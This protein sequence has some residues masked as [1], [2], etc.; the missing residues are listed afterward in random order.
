[1]FKYNHVQVIFNR[2]KVVPKFLNKNADIF[3]NNG[4]F[5][6]NNFVTNIVK[7]SHDTFFEA[8]KFPIVLGQYLCLIPL[9]QKKPQWFSFQILISLAMICCQTLMA[10]L[11]LLWLN[12]SGISIFKSG[13]VLF[14]GGAAI[15]MLLMIRLSFMWSKLLKKWTEIEYHFG[16]Q[17][18]LKRVFAIIS[19]L[20]IVFSTVLLN[21]VEHLSNLLFGLLTTYQNSRKILKIYS[22]KMFPQVFE[23]VPYTV[24]RA[25]PIL[26]INFVSTLTYSFGDQLIIMISLALGNY[27]HLFNKE[28]FSIKGKVLSEFEWKILR[29]KY[30]KLCELTSVVDD[31]LCHLLCLTFLIH[32][33][34]ICVEL[35][36][37][38][39]Y[40]SDENDQMHAILSFIVSVLRACALCYTTIR[41]YEQSKN[42]LDILHSIEL[43]LQQVIQNDTVL[44]GSHLFSMKRSFLLT[45]GGTIISYEI[46]LLQMKDFSNSE[47]LEMKIKT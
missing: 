45:I 38:I 21:L 10:I 27:F 26:Y 16:Y 19:S 5:L 9:S 6:E 11:S 37:G 12:R 31:C 43:F 40:T 23:V 22:A 20:I 2:T 46:L 39:Q 44:T 47:I 8:T 33:Y 29:L 1:M 7:S 36:Q 28:I 15:M 18:N 35:H 14:F 41:I 3:F 17:K 24:W 4:T 25:V 32:L 34:I 13:G 42:V 30:T